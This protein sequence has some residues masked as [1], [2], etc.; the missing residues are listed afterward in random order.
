MIMY[1][2]FVLVPLL[3]IGILSIIDIAKEVRKQKKEEETNKLSIEPIRGQSHV[4][5]ENHYYCNSVLV[6]LL[7]K[8]VHF[9][10][11]NGV[12]SG[13]WFVQ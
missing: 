6:E 3:V 4:F 11:N 13:N 7:N 12:Q 8:R 2:L 5:G 1:P 9:F 10:C